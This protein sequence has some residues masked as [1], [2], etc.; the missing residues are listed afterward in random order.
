MVCSTRMKVPLTVVV[1]AEP[2][3]NKERLA[4]M[5]LIVCR[6]SARLAYVWRGRVLMVF[7]KS[8]RRAMWTVEKTVRHVWPAATASKLPT[9]PHQCAAMVSV[10]WPPVRTVYSTRTRL[11]STEVAA[12]AASAEQDRDAFRQILVSAVCVT[13]RQTHA[14]MRHVRTE[15]STATKVASMADVRVRTS[16]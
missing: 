15:Y 10:L 11:A 7:F 5:R 8:A 14:K 1:C 4:R 9:V 13:R 2:H 6:I 16:V 12:Y 3:V